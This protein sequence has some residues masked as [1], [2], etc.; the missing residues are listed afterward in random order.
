MQEKKRE[1]RIE[2]IVISDKMNKTRV[3][4]T[5]DIIKHPVY[6]KYLKIRKKYYAHDE[7]NKSKIGDKVVL[8][9]SI[10]ISR[11]KRWIIVDIESKAG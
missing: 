5:E 3:V 4:K 6:G 9:P 10:P 1:I 7:E 11:T 2:G 8:K